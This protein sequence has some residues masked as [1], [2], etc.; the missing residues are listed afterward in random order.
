MN[1]SRLID[2]IILIV[3]LIGVSTFPVNYFVH[4]LFW[5][6]TIEALLMLAILL[7]LL[8]F[9]KRH[10][11]VYGYRKRVNWI[12]LLWLLPAITVAFSM[13]IFP[14]HYLNVCST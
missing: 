11:D 2:Q 9:D 1:K 6:F 8:Y 5:Y 14:L 10:V 7:F 13:L 4:D 12:N 3:L